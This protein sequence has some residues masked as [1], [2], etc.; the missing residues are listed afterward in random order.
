MP[1]FFIF[2]LKNIAISCV[3]QNVSL[4]SRTSTRHIESVTASLNE[5]LNIN[6][7]LSIDGRPKMGYKCLYSYEELIKSILVPEKLQ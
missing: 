7:N 6:R 2:Y 1:K 4:A 5:N 3:F